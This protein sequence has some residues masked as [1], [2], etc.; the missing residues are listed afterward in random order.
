MTENQ[1]QSL[2][3][4]NPELQT[5]SEPELGQPNQQVSDQKQPIAVETI[6]VTRIMFADNTGMIQVQ[7]KSELPGVGLTMNN[8]EG[9]GL[10]M[11]GIL[12]M[13]SVAIVNP[14]ESE[15]KSS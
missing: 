10:L 15:K 6:S 4:G 2:Q 12:N 8:D 1:E 7:A 9:I 3:E 14:N 5:S 13:S 11:K